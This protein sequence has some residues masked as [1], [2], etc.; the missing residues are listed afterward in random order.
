[1][2][3]DSIEV[4]YDLNGGELNTNNLLA[5]D[6][7]TSR[8]V[9][10]ALVGETGSRIQ[11]NISSLDYKMTA[12][13]KDNNVI[14]TSNVIDLPLESMVVN[15]RYDSSTKKV[16]LTLQNGNTIEFSVADLI[17][18]LESTSN[19]V[20]SISASSTNTQYPTAKCV[21]NLVGNIESLLSSI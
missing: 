16:V 1:M 21:Y 8:N 17:S 15:G 13:L 4:V 11:L 10:Y 19:K 12:I 18:G 7:V 6:E 5:G 14:Y 20:T 2:A 9:D 3:L